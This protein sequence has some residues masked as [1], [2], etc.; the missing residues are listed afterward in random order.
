VLFLACVDGSYCQQIL[1]APEV[2]PEG[3]EIY[4]LDVSIDG[5]WVAL[6]TND[7]GNGG[8]VYI[9]NLA[10]TG[11]T[12]VYLSDSN[13]LNVDWSPNSEYIVYTREGSS[14][15]PYNSMEVLHIASQT[16]SR[17]VDGLAELRSTEDCVS[18]FIRNPTWSPNG[19]QILYDVWQECQLGIE[20]ERY[21]ADVTCDQQTH[22]CYIG[23]A[24]PLEWASHR[25][26]LFWASGGSQIVSVSVLGAE[27]L[28]TIERLGQNGALY[29]AL[30]VDGGS[31]GV[32]Q[33]T[34]FSL[35]PSER[36]LAIN[37]PYRRDFYLIDL[38]TEELFDLSDTCFSNAQQFDWMP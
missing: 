4:D 21:I 10:D 1:S 13:L 28:I 16:V 6:L 24:T 33:Q 11:V 8:N 17:L 34:I 7:W 26:R 23:Q 2:L 19:N 15:E 37:N 25:R 29:D 18:L 38:D 14:T 20:D 9:L 12:E 5:Q 3:Q 35:S 27:D 30:T 31:L 22:T 32:S 36:Y